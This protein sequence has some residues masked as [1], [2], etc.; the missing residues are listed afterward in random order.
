MTSIVKKVLPPLV[1][2]LEKS[3]VCWVLCFVQ[4]WILHPLAYRVVSFFSTRLGYIGLKER[5]PRQLTAMSVLEFWGPY[6][7][8]LLFSNF[9]V[10]WCLFHV[11][12]L[13]FLNV[14]GKS[15]MKYVSSI[16][17]NCT[18]LNYNAVKFINFMVSFSFIMFSLSQ[19]Y[20]ILLYFAS[21]RFK[22]LFFTFKF[23]ISEFL[24]VFWWRRILI[25]LFYV[26]KVN[27]FI[28]FSLSFPGEFEMPSLRYS[29][30]CCCLVA[31]T[32]IPV[33]HWC[34]YLAWSQD[35]SVSLTIILECV[36]CKAN[37]TP[38]FCSHF[39]E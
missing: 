35:Y 34:I 29:E 2:W 37:P 7:V 3:L 17:S 39:S 20:E 23:W 25:L 12:Y 4:G 16:L 30:F 27:C 19:V 13:E 15:K 22:V 11:F 31:L 38:L 9:R 5:T 28:I 24:L 32:E 18:D 6:T 10:F 26:R 8:P 36:E 1:L 33:V 14:I 21:N